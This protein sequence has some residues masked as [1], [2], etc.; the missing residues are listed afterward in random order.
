M[1]RYLN[2]IAL[3]I[4]AEHICG[5]LHS[6]AGRVTGYHERSTADRRLYDKRRGV[7]GVAHRGTV[8]LDGVE[9]LKLCIGKVVY[10]TDVYGANGSIQCG[11]G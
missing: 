3:E 11:S 6:R 9:D 1:V 7:E 5:D 4:I 2:D 10:L 8:A